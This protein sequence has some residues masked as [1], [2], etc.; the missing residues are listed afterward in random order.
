ML[1]LGHSFNP[2]VP[3]SSP[4]V[5]IGTESFK[6]LFIAEISI[7]EESV[8]QIEITPAY[9]ILVEEALFCELPSINSSHCS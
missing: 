6:T 7:K 3:L 1:A 4:E 8:L 2:P 9:E 5:R